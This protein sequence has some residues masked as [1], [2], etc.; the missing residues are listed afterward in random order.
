MAKLNPVKP[1][2]R[3][4]VWRIGP[5]AQRGVIMVSRQVYLQVRRKLFS[6]AKVAQCL[7]VGTKLI[8]VLQNDEFGID[9]AKQRKEKFRCAGPIALTRPNCM[10]YYS[11]ADWKNTATNFTKVGKFMNYRSNPRKIDFN[12]LI[13]NL[14]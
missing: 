8:N 4:L 1:D 5:G 10:T 13:F 11:S 7:S 14:I 2:K 3:K 12:H 9:I 6:I